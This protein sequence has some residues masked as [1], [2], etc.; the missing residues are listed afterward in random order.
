MR[1]SDGDRILRALSEV[2]LQ[3]CSGWLVYE[4]ERNRFHLEDPEGA[5]CAIFPEQTVL[6]L[7][8]HGLL[9]PGSRGW[10]LAPKGRERLKSLDGTTSRSPAG[11]PDLLENISI[12]H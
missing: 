4:P 8:R 2:E 12:C 9:R 11:I 5:T 1:S 7:Q 10:V 6:T 3:Q